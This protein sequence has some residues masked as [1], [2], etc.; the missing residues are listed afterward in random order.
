[1]SELALLAICAIAFLGEVLAEGSLGLGT[2]AFSTLEDRLI[3]HSEV[4]LLALSRSLAL[5]VEGQIGARQIKL[6]P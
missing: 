3:I 1:M 6:F 5:D 4:A 2:R